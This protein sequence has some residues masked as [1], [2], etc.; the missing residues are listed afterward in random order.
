MVG[1]VKSARTQKA[2]GC[3]R[4]RLT[5][6]KIIFHNLKKPVTAGVANHLGGGCFFQ[7][8]RISAAVFQLK[9]RAKGGAGSARYQK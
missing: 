4:K 3:W 2:S 8:A 6:D 7:P 1:A 9:V 5:F